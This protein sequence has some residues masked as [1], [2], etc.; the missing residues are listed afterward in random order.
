M[1]SVPHRVLTTHQHTHPPTTLKM[2]GGQPPLL[3]SWFGATGLS[4]ANKAST[5][6][7]CFWVFLNFGY[8]MSNYLNI[9]ITCSSCHACTINAPN[10]G[11][12]FLNNL[13][14]HIIIIDYNIRYRKT[15]DPLF[16]FII[17]DVI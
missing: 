9:I 5:R 16:L 3:S 12:L 11:I 15:T 14:L 2:G 1:T 7:K 10:P 6:G 13:K 4:I 8:N 17:N